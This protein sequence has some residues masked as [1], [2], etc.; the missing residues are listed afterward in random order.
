[1][2]LFHTFSWP[3]LVSLF[4]M[5]SCAPDDSPEQEDENAGNNC[6]I[7][8]ILF[9]TSEFRKENWEAGE[10]VI[11]NGEVSD[12]LEEFTG[13]NAVFNM[14]NPVSSPYSVSFPVEAYG[15]NGTLVLPKDMS[16][17]IYTGYGE[18]PMLKPATGVL[19]VK[20]TGEYQDFFFEDDLHSIALKGNG[21]EQ[22]SGTF[23]YDFESRK[24]E[25]TS[26][27]EEFKSLEA[28]ID[29]DVIDFHL[30]P[31]TYKDGFTIT[32]TDKGGIS[33]DYT[34]Y[35][36]VSIKDGSYKDVPDFL[37]EPDEGHE[38]VQEVINVRSACM[39][40]NVP[41]TVITPDCYAIGTAFP[42]VYLLHGYSDNHLK[43]AAGGHI[44]DLVNKHNVIAVMPDGG[45]SSWYF[46]SP[47]MPEYKYETF[48][49]SELISYIDSHYKTIAKPSGRAITGNSMGG[50]G[51]LYLAIRHQDIFGN[52]GSTSGGVDI[53]PFPNNWDIAKRLGP[54]DQYP[55][56]WE[57]NT[58][59]NMTH[60]IGEDL[61][62]II[63]CGTE[64]FFYTVNCN[65]HSK[66]SESGIPHE[67]R[68]SPGNHSWTY[69][70]GNIGHQF[71]FFKNNFSR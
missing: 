12:P 64:D 4:F 71:E 46:D 18:K 51:A 1:M 37:S 52:A 61:N 10:Q 36:P 14:K 35:G 54:I 27:S 15:S 53:R 21:G 25:S 57:N 48:V 62:I 69:W 29:E 17:R 68:T 32:Y 31:G 33:R 67:F 22:L 40:K 50:H 26:D 55:E 9:Y 7:E 58:V 16:H 34:L 63:D 45:F 11:I 42:V 30:P 59:I 43:W 65:L 13:R 3:L 47:M 70:F 8:V 5:I 24:F 66:L 23:R 56:N 6:K 44:E 28:L 39:N 49:S 38:S 2:K 60:L 19:R 41:V 20:T